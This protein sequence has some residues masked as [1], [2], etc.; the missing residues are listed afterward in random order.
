[1]IASKQNTVTE[2]ITEQETAQETAHETEHETE[3][4]TEE[5]TSSSQITSR[6]LNIPHDGKY[7][8]TG[9]IYSDFTYNHHNKDQIL[10][11]YICDES[12]ESFL[13]GIPKYL[14]L[15][16]IYDNTNNNLVITDTDKVTNLLMYN[17][18]I[19]DRY[20]F[21]KF[22]NK[23]CYGKLIDDE[24]VK[25]LIRISL[26]VLHIINSKLRHTD[27][28]K[29]LSELI[30][31]LQ[32]IKY[33]DSF[34]FEKKLNLNYLR[35]FQNL[36]GIYKKWADRKKESDD[37]HIKRSGTADAHEYYAKYLKY[38]TKYLNLKNKK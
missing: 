30:Q 2:Q 38:K 24:L 27:K 4:E 17:E 6:I 12:Y 15:L 36:E 33:N 13:T 11:A 20:T 19:N 21:I 35:F 25:H 3:Q 26:G 1:V 37:D 16:L 22:Y 29:S 9:I 23:S 32:N 10:V 7:D 5:D 8:S 28:K 18:N 14:D 34:N 31:Y